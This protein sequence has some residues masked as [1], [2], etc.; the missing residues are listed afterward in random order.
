[1]QK[2]SILA[3]IG[4]ILLLT[5]VGCRLNLPFIKTRTP[6][7]VPP[8]HATLPLPDPSATQPPPPTATEPP[9]TATNLPPTPTPDP[10]LDPA[11]ITLET[12]TRNEEGQ[13]PSYQLTLQYPALT[14]P[15]DERLTHFNQLVEAM[16]NELATSFKGDLSNVIADPNFG[17]VLSTQQITYT[18]TYFNQGVISVYFNVGF[19]MA[20]AAHPNSYS[21]V[22]TYDLYEDK[23][24]QLADLF[25]S[26]ADYLQALSD[27][28]VTTLTNEGRLEFPGG[29]QPSGENYKNWNLTP[30]SVRITFD[31]YQVGPYAMGPQVVDIPFSVLTPIFYNYGA[32]ARVL[33]SYQN[34]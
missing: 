28:C 19:Y 24:I 7:V 14:S 6:T 31:P 32:L 3:V 17:P 15:A 12:I 21:V 34:P 20:G 2:K 29:A 23:Q 8:T 4:I 33:N 25:I 18:V 13:N 9:S 27:Y 5:L 16:I 11:G 30:D 26:G 10:V 1:M 22:L